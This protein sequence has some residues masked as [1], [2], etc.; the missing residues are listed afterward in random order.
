MLFH[1]DPKDIDRIPNWRQGREL[2]PKT[3]CFSYIP[4]GETIR[5]QKHN[6][7]QKC[8]NHKMELQSAFNQAKNSQFEVCSEWQPAANDPVRFLG[9][10]LP[11]LGSSF[12]FHRGPQP[13][14]LEPLLT[15]CLCKIPFQS[16][17]YPK[18]Q[19]LDL[20][21]ELPDKYVTKFWYHFLEQRLRLVWK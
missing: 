10:F 13:G 9:G 18:T 4:C 7:S 21:Q 14:T 8:R 5:T 20:L 2:A 3:V 1:C 6:L 12:R 11:R 16:L 15:I 19:P 17:S